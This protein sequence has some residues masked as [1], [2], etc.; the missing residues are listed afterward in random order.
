MGTIDALLPVWA[1][2]NRQDEFEYVRNDTWMLRWHRLLKNFN[3]RNEY[4][5]PFSPYSPEHA[6]VDV[7]F[8]ARQLCIDRFVVPF[9]TLDYA[10]NGS[11]IASYDERQHG[12]YAFFRFLERRWFSDAA[13]RMPTMRNL[14]ARPVLNVCTVLRFAHRKITNHEELI[15]WTKK[16]PFVDLIIP[17]FATLSLTET[18][19][20]MRSTH[21]LF[22]M[23]GA[24][25]FNAV[26]MSPAA[27]V[28]VFYH[29]LT[30]PAPFTHMTTQ[31]INA[32]ALTGHN[33]VAW[34]KTTP[35]C[36]AHFDRFMVQD[37][38]VPLEVHKRLFNASVKLVGVH[39]PNP[40]DRVVGL[41]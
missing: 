34:V 39:Y 32:V 15:I 17:D 26:F 36:E 29:C 20:L 27:V 4:V 18:V 3:M 2:L 22:A 24:A 11:P 23:H 37:I 28:L 7:R 40:Q 6:W 35:P 1:A 16:Q 8:S 19:S 21:V 41:S 5:Q 10:D 14:R 12:L 30:S 38:T 13:E 33:V 9:T 31:N 25:V